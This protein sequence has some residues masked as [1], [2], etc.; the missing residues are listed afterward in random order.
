[1]LQDFARAAGA[2]L[3]AGDPANALVTEPALVLCVSS[4]KTPEV[5]PLNN[6]KVTSI[7]TAADI[8]IVPF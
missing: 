1:M 8:S 3:G 2:F 5:D 4:A 6:M 7:A